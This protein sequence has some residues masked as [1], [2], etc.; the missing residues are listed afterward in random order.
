[1]DVLQ[2]EVTGELCLNESAYV[3]KICVEVMHIPDG[4]A[5]GDGGLDLAEILLCFAK[6]L[7]SLPVIHCCFAFFSKG[8]GVGDEKEKMIALLALTRA[9]DRLCLGGLIVDRGILGVDQ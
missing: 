4:C 5:H 1:M 3:C 6:E 2:G 7:I 9:L 8:L